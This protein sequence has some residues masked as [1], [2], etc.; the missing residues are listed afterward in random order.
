MRWPSWSLWVPDGACTL[1]TLILA[2]VSA[3]TGVAYKCWA[4]RYKPLARYRFDRIRLPEQATRSTRK[5]VKYGWPSV[6]RKQTCSA[7]APQLAHARHVN[8][9]RVLKC[10]SSRGACN[11]PTS[12]NHMMA[13]SNPRMI[14]P[15]VNCHCERCASQCFPVCRPRFQSMLAKAMVVLCSSAAGRSCS[16]A[17]AAFQTQPLAGRVAMLVERGAACPHRG[18]GGGRSVLEPTRR[19]RRPRAPRWRK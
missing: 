1:I 9:C 2:R 4:V 12:Q 8:S 14:S 10:A 6:C 16:A 17:A 13:G 7:E 5:A 18:S 11:S 19:R 15:V 3:A